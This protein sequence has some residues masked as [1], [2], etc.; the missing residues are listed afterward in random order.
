MLGLFLFLLTAMKWITKLFA[1]FLI[2]S[3]FGCKSG[4]T[5]NVVYR[6]NSAKADCVGVAPMS[7]LQVQKG[8]SIG[9]N[10][11][12]YFYSPI[13]GFN[14]EPGNIY[15]ISV[16]QTQLPK[17]QIPADGSSLKFELIEV[18]DKAQDPLLALNDV[19]VVIEIL[20]SEITK[21]T[22][23]K[24]PTMEIFVSERRVTGTNGCNIY[25]ATIEHLTESEIS[26]SP[27]GTTRM[28]CADM[29]IP[30]SFDKAITEVSGYSRKNG[31]VELKSDKG[32]VLIVL[33]KID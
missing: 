13:E 20:G 28:M 5:I 10:S 27:A 12:E 24:T 8:D 16:K 15:T 2:T 3:L 22:L 6:V 9:T 31:I 30:D 18:L 32:E 1:L 7:C 4:K 23:S 14:Y 25:Y 33:K 17:S 26:F 11:W 21:D 19:Y 29:T